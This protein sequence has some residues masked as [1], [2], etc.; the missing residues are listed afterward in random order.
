MRQKINIAIDGPAG[1]GKSTIAKLVAEQLQFIYIDTGAM[2]RA[3]TYYAIQNGFDMDDGKSLAEALNRCSIKLSYE[4]NGLQIYVNE[5]N[6]T[7][8]IRT[9]L[10]SNHVSKVASHKDVR[11][12]MLQLQ[13]ELARDGG[14]VM[15]GRDIGTHVL[16]NAEVKIFLTAST[17]E[18]AKRRH[19]ENIQK[20]YESDFEKIKEDII[21]RDHMD[22]T[23]KEAPLR[24]ADDAIEIDSTHLSID[25]VVQKIMNIVEE[26]IK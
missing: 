11:R 17:D 15:D 20:G 1:A 23:R 10:V 19:K 22:I 16:P 3:L 18:R 5:R 4:S 21:R 8:D 26:R 12:K 7:E 9:D 24:K 14:T 2:Y 13:Q 6:V 25:D